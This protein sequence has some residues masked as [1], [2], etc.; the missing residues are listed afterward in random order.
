M[1]RFPA[2][3]PDLQGAAGG[4]HPTRQPPSRSAHLLTRRLASPSSA[5]GPPTKPGSRA[6]SASSWMPT[7]RSRTMVERATIA[8]QTAFWQFVNLPLPQ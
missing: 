7:I 2:C 4:A 6:N 1:P 5:G 3:G 8:F